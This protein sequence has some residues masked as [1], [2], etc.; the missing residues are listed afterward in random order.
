MTAT[1]DVLHVT[2]VDM[3]RKER[4]RQKSDQSQRESKRKEVEVVWACNAKHYVGRRVMEMEVQE[5]RKRKSL[6]RR[7]WDRVRGDIKEM[8]RSGE[9]VYDQLH[10]GI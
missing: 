5:R 2:K 4:K 3:I 1:M 9:E 10:G 8:G 6:E 7:W